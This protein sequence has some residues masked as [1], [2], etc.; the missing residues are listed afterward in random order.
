MANWGKECW[1]PTNEVG[2]R[3]EPPQGGSALSPKEPK[4]TPGYGTWNGEGY[5]YEWGE[6]HVT[7]RPSAVFPGTWYCEP[8][9]YVAL[10]VP[11]APLAHDGTPGCDDGPECEEDIT[12][13]YPPPGKQYEGVIIRADNPR[14][15]LDTC[16]GCAT[17]LCPNPQGAETGCPRKTLR[18]ADLLKR[19]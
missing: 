18:V 9:E 4:E 8:V 3:G 10:H 1:Q 16:E 2:G 13:I 17:T 14:L 5:V 6:Y 15:R 12:W 19:T 11:W 7:M